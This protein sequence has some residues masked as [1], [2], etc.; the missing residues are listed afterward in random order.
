MN[1]V[2]GMNNN[3]RNQLNCAKN[4]NESTPEKHH[5]LFSQDRNTMT[6]HGVTDVISFDENGVF[7]VTTCGQLNLE[8]SG[9]HVAVLNTEDGIVEVTGRINGLLYYDKPEEHSSRRAR[10]QSRW[11]S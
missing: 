6:I 8:G 10:R 1:G 2:Q 7:L 5:S 9:L 11:F 4:S 3:S